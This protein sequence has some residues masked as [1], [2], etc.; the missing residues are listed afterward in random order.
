MIEG[1]YVR[2][3]AI[4]KLV[5]QFLTTKPTQRKQ[6]ISLGAGT[7]TRYFRIMLHHQSPGEPRFIY[8]ELDFP[9][10]TARKLRE[11]K[12][13][14]ELA[15]ALRP[16]ISY[17]NTS[18]LSDDPANIVD[19]Q[20]YYVHPIDLRDLDPTK[21]PPPTFE[22][23]DRSLPTL[24]LSECCLVYLEPAAA[25]IVAQYFSRHLF[26]SSTPLGIVL[27]EPI[28]PNDAFGKV[29]VSNLAARG[30]V[31]QTLKKYGSLEAQAARMNSYG[32]MDSRGADV[33]HLWEKGVH[34]MEK[35]RVAR[36]EM[37]DEVEEWK[38]LAGH[39]AVVWG[40]RDGE[41]ERGQS[42]W[43]PWKDLFL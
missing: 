43:E 6:I 23:I 35:E 7:D 15:S 4:D 37:V 19:S 13:H 29:M 16:P 20:Y 26:P 27:Y 17:S 14:T 41:L 18:N 1:T 8:H 3:K 40:W 12:R 21:E 38:L 10:N 30:I 39:Y 9:K 28:N 32:F 31:L 25:D 24:V 42:L 11:V 5:E 34:E 22:K 36:L 33:D 2:T